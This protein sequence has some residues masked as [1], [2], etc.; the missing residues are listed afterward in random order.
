M[1]LQG[2]IVV[3]SKLYIIKR[4]IE[5][6]HY[7]HNVNGVRISHCF[8]MYR[9]YNDSTGLFGNFFDHEVEMAG[10]A[11]FGSPAM[12]NVAESWN[13]SNPDKCLELRRLCCIDDTPKNAESFF[14]GRMLRWLRKHTTYETVVSYADPHYGH[15]GT[16]YKASNFEYVGQTAAGKVLDVDGELYHDRTLRNPKPYAQKIK[17]R[18]IDGDDDIK[19]I[20]VPAKHIYL[21]HLQR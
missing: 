5:T 9:P 2:Y 15:E 6:H 18:L 17:Q 19:W 16:I 13:P 7:S 12:S 21:Y 11:I 10:A 8:A 1:A 14:I 3:P 20:D 4:F